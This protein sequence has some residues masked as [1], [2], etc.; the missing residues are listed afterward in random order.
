MHNPQYHLEIYIERQH[1]IINYTEEIQS[2]WDSRHLAYQSSTHITAPGRM[3][4][5]SQ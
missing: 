1:A 5:N 4:T 3:D 2:F